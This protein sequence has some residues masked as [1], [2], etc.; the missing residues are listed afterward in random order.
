MSVVS[1]LAELDRRWQDL[2]DR[3]AEL[4][5]QV[6]AGRRDHFAWRDWW[7]DVATFWH[8]RNLSFADSY[9]CHAR[10]VRKA[11]ECEAIIASLGGY[12]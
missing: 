9:G 2:I 8:K 10:A 6:Q 12:L 7:W 4:V 3:E 5:A 11:R 1:E